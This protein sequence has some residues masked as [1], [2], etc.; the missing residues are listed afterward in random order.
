MFLAVF[1]HFLENASFV[2]ANIFY[3][4]GLDHSLHFLLRYGGR[5]NLKNKEKNDFLLTYV[6][7]YALSRDFTYEVRSLAKICEK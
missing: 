5:K 7:F 4:D 1:R 2:L 6:V 3:L